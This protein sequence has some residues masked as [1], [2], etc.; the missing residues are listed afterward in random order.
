MTRYRFAEFVVS[1]RRRVLLH[2][3]REQPLIPRY[4]D[5]LV[6]LIERRADAVH[7]RDIFDRVWSD[8]IVSDSA[9]SQAI[10]T[11]RRALGDDSREPRFVKTVSRH[12]YQFVCAELIEEADDGVWPPSRPSASPDSRHG[13]TQ[14]SPAAAESQSALDDGPGARDQPEWARLIELITVQPSTA[15]AEE[16]QRDAAERLH[17]LGTAEALARLGSAADAA[18]ARALL[19]DTRWDVPGAGDVSI[20]GQPHATTIA[21]HLVRIRLRR[22]LGVIASRWA[23]AAA[24][25]GLAGLIGGLAGGLLLVLA[26]A[27]STSAAVVPVLGLIGAVC[28]ALAG[29]GVGAGI[30][31]AEAIMRSHRTLAL[32]IGGALGGW[33]VGVSIQLMGR[34]MLDVLVGVA[35]P[36]GG[37]IEG[38]TIGLAAGLGFAGATRG[39]SG[40]QAAP[41][42]RSRARAAGF[43]AAACAAAALLMSISGLPLVGGSIHLIAQASHGGGEPLL[44]PLGRLIG[45]PDFGPVSAALIAMGEGAAFGLGLALGITRRR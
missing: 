27:G 10:R 21:R 45:E 1:P 22:L 41:R 43:P 29:A 15:V 30:A 7:R 18:F 34:W 5:L 37:L 14:A 11:V 28:G 3:G 25:A 39:A 19:R 33:I 40:G 8:V 16:D 2:K 36:I 35:P 38:A 6:F 24:G 23:A 20:V 26:S 17:Q 31:V 44:A 9:L 12:G 32:G 13:V 4:F 42:G